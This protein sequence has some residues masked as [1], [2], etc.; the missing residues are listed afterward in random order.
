[1]TSISDPP[2]LPKLRNMAKKTLSH[3]P[4]QFSHSAGQKESTQDYTVTCNPENT[5]PRLPFLFSS[6]FSTTKCWFL[7]SCCF[8]KHHFLALLPAILDST[9][10]LILG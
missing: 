6:D 7:P 3:P 4:M 9:H 10:S 5:R 2:K 1:M 8:P